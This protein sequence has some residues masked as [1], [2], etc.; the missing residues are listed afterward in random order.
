M[1]IY[2]TILVIGSFIPC[3]VLG[4]DVG[5]WRAGSAYTL[6][7]KIY[8]V[9][10]FVSGPDDQW[11]PEVKLKMLN[12][13]NEGNKWLS[14]QAARFKVSLSFDGENFGLIHDI[15]LLQIERGTASG[16]ERV[17]LVSVVLGKIGYKSALD[18]YDELIASSKCNNLQVLIFI[19]GEGTGYSMAYSNEMNKDMYFVEGSVLYEK[20]WNN[21]EIAP[22]SIAHEILHLYGAWDLY[23]TFQQTQDN[24]DKARKLF[25]D[26]IMLRTSYDINDLNVDEVTAWLIGWNNAPKAWYEKFRP[27]GK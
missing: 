22:S 6:D 21:Q 1:N 11:K 12:K 19:K 26:S 27:P 15:K 23:K 5:K 25:P 4:Q 24:E 16:K 3:L 18:L 10:C 7:G 9:S 20:Y 2:K 14:E 8:T 17:D 13:L